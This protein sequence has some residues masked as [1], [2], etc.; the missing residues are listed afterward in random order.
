MLARIEKDVRK[1]RPDFTRRPER[2]VVVS[3]VQ[4]CAAPT[5]D[6]VHCARESRSETLDSIRERRSAVGFDQQVH[7][8][9]LERVVDD[10]EI[11]A[12]AERSERYFDLTHEAR[13]SHRGHV[14]ADADRHQAR[15][16]LGKVCALA[17]PHPRPRSRPPARAFPRPTPT[18]G[19]LQV[20]REL[21]AMRHT[22]DCGYVLVG[23]QELSAKRIV[24]LREIRN[25]MV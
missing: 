12:L 16:A 23:C 13:G 20:K 9:V 2:A 6:P 10:A 24:I 8:I 7:V 4:D 22:L 1:R 21:T 19:N 14:A 11:P 25:H 17:M 3:P 5:E 15:V 18:R